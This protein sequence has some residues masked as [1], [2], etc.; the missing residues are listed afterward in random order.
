LARLA[1]SFAGLRAIFFV[2]FDSMVISHSRLYGS[3]R[4]GWLTALGTVYL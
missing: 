3:E 2:V 1:A 4:G